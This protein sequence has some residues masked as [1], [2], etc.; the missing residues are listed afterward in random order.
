MVTS[1]QVAIE[2]WTTEDLLS[3]YRRMATIRQFEARAYELYTQGMIQGAIHSYAGEEAVAVGVLSHLS[4]RDY[5]FST[6]RGHGHFAARGVP[7]YRMAAELL[8]RRDGLS[9]GKGGSMHFFDVTRGMMG[10]N[11]IVGANLPLAVG[12]GLSAKLR[13][14][15]QVSLSFFGDGASNQGTFHEALN[16]A[17]LWK[18][19]VVFVCEN[20]HYAMS[21]HV[22]RST[23]VADIAVRAAGY[24][25]PGV[26]VD[27]MDV[28]AVHREAAQAIE[29]A[30][31]G[32]GPSL[33]EAKTQRF[34]GHSRGDPP[35]GL[36][37]SKG[38]WEEAKARDPLLLFAATTS[39]PEGEL[40]RIDEEVKA[41]VRHAFD[42][43][44]ACPFPDP[45]TALEGIFA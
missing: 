37:R 16:L 34:S 20:N 38:E 44:A 19:P 43:A 2:G 23:S 35:H 39:L 15:G 1:H 21:T 36:Y 22:T 11:G 12:A 13:N 7:L 26:T 45:E 33:I 31:R 25:M 17:S 9:G 29:R 27:G 10:C 40:R 5:V 18:L 32:D 14:S 4:D 6:H 30:R 24:G 3:I 42:L 8:G 41:E 28:F